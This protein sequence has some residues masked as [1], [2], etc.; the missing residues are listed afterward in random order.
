MHEYEVLGFKIQKFASLNSVFTAAKHCFAEAKHSYAAE[1]PWGGHFGLRLHHCEAAFAVA[2]DFTTVK[3]PFTTVKVPF[4]TAKARFA[5]F[6][7]S[8]LILPFSL[9]ITQ[10]VKANYGKVSQRHFNIILNEP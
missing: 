10:K 1:N 4:T 6:F 9:K 7:S 3:V 2:K 5:Q 8:L